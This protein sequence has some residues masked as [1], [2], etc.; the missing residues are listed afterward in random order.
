MLTKFRK[1]A[2]LIFICMFYVFCCQGQKPT[3]AYTIKYVTDKFNANC[4]GLAGSQTERADDFTIFHSYTSKTFEISE[5]D[6]EPFLNFE[7]QHKYRTSDRNGIRINETN[8]TKY[9]IPILKI[10]V[11]EHYGITKNNP[12][13]VFTSGIEA[14]F[15]LNLEMAILMKGK[16]IQSTNEDNNMSY[17]LFIAL[18][19]ASKE[20]FNKIKKAI[21]NLKSYY[22]IK[23]DPFDN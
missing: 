5:K 4:T 15:F 13:T 8:S 2:L 12:D 17:Q 6:N 3:K 10:S 18:P 21:D 16:D 23:K 20:E 11:I 19:C 9:K 7:I 14:S 1:E 22:K